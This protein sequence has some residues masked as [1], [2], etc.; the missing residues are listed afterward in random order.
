MMTPQEREHLRRYAELSFGHDPDLIARY[1]A[2]EQM[3][4]QPPE[5]ERGDGE[6]RERSGANSVSG[7]H[8]ANS[9]IDANDKEECHLVDDAKDLRD[10]AEALR[11][12][13][14]KARESE[15]QSTGINLRAEPKCGELLGEMAEGGELETGGRPEQSHDATASLSDLAV[16][17]QE[18]SRFQQVA[19][20]RV[21]KAPPRRLR[22]PLIAAG[23]VLGL[24]AAMSLWIA[25]G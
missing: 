6:D 23:I 5:I 1:L 14:K 3:T 16:D 13:L 7:S 22:W 2:G 18:S 9:D 11:A 21:T 8:L 20:A 19:S 12:Y 24:F 25:L 4:V 17:K 15:A 10:K